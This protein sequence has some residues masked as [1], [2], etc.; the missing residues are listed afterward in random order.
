MHKEN[1]VPKS[2]MK[3]EGELI[4]RYRD[5]RVTQLL[6][7]HNRA[8][9][10]HDEL[11]SFGEATY[12]TSEA[13]RLS[14]AEAYRPI[15]KIDVLERLV[16]TLKKDIEQRVITPSDMME[17]IRELVKDMSE[18]GALAI[19]DKPGALGHVTLLTDRFVKNIEA[20]AKDPIAQLEAKAKAGA[21]SIPL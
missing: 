8:T 19:K 3:Q 11:N 16:S 6:K 17:D 9:P 10:R 13:L 18:P 5:N 14:I 2:W 4:A 1:E 20:L 12:I 21:P 7:K 15:T